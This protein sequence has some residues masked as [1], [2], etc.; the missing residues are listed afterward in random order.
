M[1]KTSKIKDFIIREIPRHES[2]IVT[3]S[4]AKLN[5]SRQTIHYHLK[6]LIKEGK[7]IATGKK[8]GSR[9]FLKSAKK[10]SFSLR[11]HV[12]LAE[13]RVLERY[14]KP[15]MKGLKDN[16]KAIVSYGFSEIFNNVLEHSNAN[17]VKVDF[18]INKG[19]IVLKIIDNGVGIFKKVKEA[20]DLDDFRDAVLELSKGKFT[21][22]KEK[23]TGEGIFFTSRIFDKC[24]ISSDN[25]MYARMGEEDFSI[26]SLKTSRGTSVSLYIEC[27]SAKKLE[28]LFT[29]YTDRETYEFSST[30][31]GVSLA[32]REDDWISRSQA[33]RILSGLEKFAVVMLDF[34][35][36]KRVGQAFVDEVFRVF[37]NK[38]PDIEIK[39]KNANSDIDFMIKR[40][41]K[42]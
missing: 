12:G 32:D 27:D 15:K 21:T 41:L 13:D 34:R 11:V 1:D 17:N 38:Y 6:R 28:D 37:K 23:H 33:R 42:R 31:V 18:D 14:I 35:G 30:E 26:E 4:A 9:Y 24:M 10:I 29:K 39:Y 40:G 20:L 22:D 16:V 2:D 5:L 7:V 19:K 3:Y 36:V 25:I 8:K